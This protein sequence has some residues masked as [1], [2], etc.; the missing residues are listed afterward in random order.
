MRGFTI[1]LLAIFTL[2][3]VQE[4]IGGEIKGAVSS[5]WFERCQDVVVFIEAVDSTNVYQPPKDR[6]RLDQRDLTFVPH[7]LPIVVGTTVDFPN[8]D[9]VQHNVFSPS[10]TKKFD[11]GSYPPKEFK[12]VTFDRPGKVVVLCN[13]H[14]E[15]SAYIIVLNNPYFALTD[16]EGSFV[17][18]KIPPGKYRVSTWHKNLKTATR[19]VTVPAKGTVVVDFELMIGKAADLLELLK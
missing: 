3:F 8:N 4:G 11:L 16:E 6:P 18:S 5:K 9:K 12:S 17:I 2:A 10:K 14:P 13:V 15:M 1:S 7:V 19:K